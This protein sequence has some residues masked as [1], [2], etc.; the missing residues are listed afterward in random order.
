MMVVMME[1][2]SADLMVEM[3]ELMM[4]AKMDMRIVGK[5]GY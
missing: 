1:V 5:L 4:V 2:L 3:M